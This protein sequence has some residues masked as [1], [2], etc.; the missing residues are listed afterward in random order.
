MTD[1]GITGDLQLKGT[2]ALVMYLKRHT[3]IPIGSLGPVHFQAGYYVYV[4]S[5]QGGLEARLRYHL[6]PTKRYHWHIDYLLAHASLQSVWY[7]PGD[8]QECFL[9]CSLAD[10]FMQLPKFG[11]SDC[12]CTSHLFYSATKVRI[13]RFFQARQW[14]E[15]KVQHVPGDRL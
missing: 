3:A 14:K 5:A 10:N 7:Q 12:R 8:N 2:Y 1:C 4:G 13:H 9:A 11:S 6:S 15:I